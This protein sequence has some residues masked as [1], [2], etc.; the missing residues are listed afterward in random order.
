MVPWHS[1]VS[2]VSLMSDLIDSFFCEGLYN[3]VYIF[4]FNVTDRACLECIFRVTDKSILRY[5]SMRPRFG[6]APQLCNVRT[7]YEWESACIANIDLEVT[8]SISDAHREEIFFYFSCKIST[9]NSPGKIRRPNRE[10]DSCKE[11]K[12]YIETKKLRIGNKSEW[13]QDTFLPSS[14]MFETWASHPSH[15]V[16]IFITQRNDWRGQEFARFPNK[17]QK[18]CESIKHV[19]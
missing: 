16:V 1:S 5:A 6:N 15:F 12:F 13:N 2:L 19:S 9:K 3:N 14:R 10:M 11:F 4:P 18:I 8:T 17:C 7:I